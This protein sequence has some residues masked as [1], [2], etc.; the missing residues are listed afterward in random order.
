LTI[1][2]SKKGCIVVHQKAQRAII[3]EAYRQAIIKEQ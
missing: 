2:M 1:T 3:N